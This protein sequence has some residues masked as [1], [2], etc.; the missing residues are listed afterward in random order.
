MGNLVTAITDRANAARLEVKEDVLHGCAEYMALLARW[1]QR[2]NLTSLPLAD[3]VPPG[4]ID[5]LIIEPLVASSLLFPE[6]RHWVD[7]GSGGG[8]PAIPLRL[9]HR[10]GTLRMVEA[11]ARKCA[12]LREAARFLGLQDTHVVEGQYQTLSSGRP[13]DIVTIRALR[14]D[15]ELLSTLRALLRHGGRVLAFGGW[16]PSAA[17]FRDPSRRQL[18]DGSF[19]AEVVLDVPRGTEHECPGSEIR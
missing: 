12:F 6:D 14:V 5:K 10:I 13:V 9:A 3:P 18:P 15:E 1:T 7:L 4:S 17:G 11:R 8:S 16:P 19:L 2:M